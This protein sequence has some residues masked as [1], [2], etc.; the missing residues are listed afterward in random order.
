MPTIQC[1]PM[2]SQATYKEKRSTPK[3]HMSSSK[4]MT[5]TIRAAKQCSY[6]RCD[7]TP[8][9]QAHTD[10]IAPPK[11]CTPLGPLPPH[12]HYHNP[13]IP[14]PTPSLHTR[15]WS[16]ATPCYLGNDALLQD[17][18]TPLK[19]GVLQANETLHVTIMKDIP[20]AVKKTLMA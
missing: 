15:F 7:H 19:Y 17:A 16:Q 3:V 2:P 12:E 20:Q 6:T 10:S 4:V 9:F 1:R 13:C 5:Y 8:P 11:P 14:K 18:N